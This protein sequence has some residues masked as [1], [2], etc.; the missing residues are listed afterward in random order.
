MNNP[1][2][3]FSAPFAIAHR[4]GALENPENTLAAFEDSINLGYKVLETDLRLTRDGVLAIH[5]DETLQRSADLPD[6]IGGR[7]WK[8][9]STIKVFGNHK[10]LTL[11]ELVDSIPSD[12]VLNIDPKDY[13]VVGPLANFL[14]RRPEMQSRICLG[15]FSSDRLMRIREKLPH[16]AMSLGGREI[17][18]MVINSRLNRMASSLRNKFPNQIALQVPV[19]AY[20]IDI[21]RPQFVKFVHDLG[22]QV[23]VWV[24][25][26]PDEMHRL[27]DMGVDAIMTDRPRILKQVLQDRGFWR[28]TG[29]GSSKAPQH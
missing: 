22:M 2:S 23:H 7:T 24:V 27:Y 18:A 4:G 6:R 12:I 25:D 15:S 26:E 14:E 21:V 10:I 3:Q 8:E 20:G 16:I 9:L 19:R 11:D 29:H 17:A 28:G 13:E 5:H 1:Y